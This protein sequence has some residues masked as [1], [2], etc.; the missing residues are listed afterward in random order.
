MRDGLR[1]CVCP[2]HPLFAAFT[3]DP[4]GL[5]APFLAASDFHRDQQLV[6]TVAF[7]AVTKGG[8]R[9]FKGHAD[10]IT[11]GGMIKKELPKAKGRVMWVTH[12]ALVSINLGTFIPQYE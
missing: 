12:E 2:Q 9:L 11:S 10:H 7:E 4:P 8:A 6:G 1:A 3:S 5:S